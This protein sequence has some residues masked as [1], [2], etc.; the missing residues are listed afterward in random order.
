MNAFLVIISVLSSLIAA[1]IV[2][3]L[4]WMVKKDEFKEYRKKL[5]E[6]EESKQRIKEDMENDRRKFE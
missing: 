6:F 4:G 3:L 2:F 1:Y 5:R